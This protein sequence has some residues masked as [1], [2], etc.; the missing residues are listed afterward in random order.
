M[1][2]KAEESYKKMVRSAAS[3]KRLIG[4]FQYRF[5]YP[6][7]ENSETKRNRKKYPPQNS[8]CREQN[9]RF[10]ASGRD[11]RKRSEGHFYRSVWKRWNHHSGRKTVIPRGSFH[12]NK[13]NIDISLFLSM[14]TWKSSFSYC[15]EHF[16]YIQSDKKNIWYYVELHRRWWTDDFYHMLH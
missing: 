13:G 11:S 14:I 7:I 9:T 4:S 10:N 15:D 8:S 6:E 3:L 5:A 12:W 2:R 16:S 1:Y